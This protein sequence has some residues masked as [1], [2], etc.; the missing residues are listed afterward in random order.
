MYAP[1]VCRFKTYGLLLNGELF[2]DQIQNFCQTILV[3]KEVQE[4]NQDAVN[5]IEEIDE[6][7]MEF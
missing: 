6:L 5:E 7:E 3:M 4:W 2:S 1:V